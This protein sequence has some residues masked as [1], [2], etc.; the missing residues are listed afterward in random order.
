M[1][2]EQELERQVGDVLRRMPAR[3]APA[4]LAVR[5]MEAV[6]ARQ[7]LPW[8]RQ[9]Y[10]SWPA[11]ARA[12]MGGGLGGLAVAMVALGFWGGGWAMEW[13]GGWGGRG[14]AVWNAIQLLGQAGTG[15]FRQILQPWLLGVWAVSLVMYLFCLGAGTAY[16]RLTWRRI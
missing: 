13:V 5:V 2:P 10:W 11:W 15:A 8:W 3:R 12:L 14:A 4:D 9:A 6:A 16:F 7:R 1:N